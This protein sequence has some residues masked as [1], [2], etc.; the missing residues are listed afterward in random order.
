MSPG[1]SLTEQYINEIRSRGLTASDLLPPDRLPAIVESFYGQRAL[2]RPV[3]FAEAEHARLVRDLSTMHAALTSLP[4]LLFGGDLGAFATAVGLTERQVGFVVRTQSGAPVTRFARADMYAD[5]TGFKLLE[6]NVGS[7]IGMIEAG[8]LNDALL[9]HPVLAGFAAEH[10]LGSVDMVAE[11]LAS[12]RQECGL[13]PDSQPVIA[14]CDW[15]DQ[16]PVNEAPLRLC[17]DMHRDSYGLTSIPTHL[18]RLEYRDGGVW[19][20]GHRIDVVYRMFMLQQATGPEANELIDPLLAAAERGEVEIFTPLG[21]QVF[22]S[23]AAL[24]MLSDEAHRHRFDAETLAALDRILP[25]TRVCRPGTVTLESGER[26][27]LLDHALAQRAELILKPALLHSGSGVLPGWEAD[28]ADWAQRV[29]AAMDGG[30]ILQR[31]VR[32]VP[33]LVPAP[34]GELTDYTINLGVFSMPSGP[35]GYGGMALRVAPVTANITVLSINADKSVLLGCAMHQLPDT[36]VIPT[37]S[38]G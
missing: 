15:P 25:W 36:P 27:E 33:Q 5:A 11:C 1:L 23:K 8:L 6:Y 22:G 14:M 30:W 16:F 38:L 32:P 21:C 12:M 34:D 13:A 10:R 2:A 26:V 9:A 19:D 17:T 28:P 24:A 7:T 29:E 4:D 35:D 18:G 31:R 20:E 37:A 3:F